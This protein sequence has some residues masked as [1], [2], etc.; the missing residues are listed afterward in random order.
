MKLIIS[1]LSLLICLNANAGVLIYEND[2]TT[3]AVEQTSSGDITTATL[4]G[5]SNDSG[6]SSP[7]D[8]TVKFKLEKNK[9][10]YNGVLTPFSSELME[11]DDTDNYLA[12]F[13]FD[14]AGMTFISQKSLDVC[15]LAT[16]FSGDYT[17]VNV[18]SK[19]YEKGFNELLQ[20]NYHNAMKV[21]RTGNKDTAIKL[22][23]PYMS[24]SI[25]R[26]FYQSDIFND[27]GYFLQQTGLNNEAIKYFSIVMEKSP[28]RM[29]TYLNIADSYWDINSRNEAINSYKKYVSMMTNAGKS[30]QIPG[31]V[32]DRIK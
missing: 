28:K 17:A 25:E 22:L 15:P 1:L 2:T 14:K 20:L 31:R 29:V 12:S 5:G 3:M 30:K 18:D 16:D 23:E 26:D 6:A 4:Y 8:C 32:F 13:E 24:E 7:A 11:Y 19:E 27:Y 21:F 10:G 9:K